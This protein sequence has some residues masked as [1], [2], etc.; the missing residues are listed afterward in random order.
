V[1]DDTL[2]AL[3]PATVERHRTVGASWLSGKATYEFTLEHAS[4]QSHV[5]NSTD[6]R[7]SPFGPGARVDHSPWTLSPGVS[8]A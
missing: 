6:P 7:V 3:F 4:N 2:T 1:P 5:N 8:R